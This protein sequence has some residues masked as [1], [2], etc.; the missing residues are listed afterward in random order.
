VFGDHLKKRRQQLGLTQQE[1][2]DKLFVSRQTISNWE[3]GKNYPDIPT[4]ISVSDHLSLSLD[5][6][7]KEDKEYIEKVG[8][9][10]QLINKE[11][12]LSQ[13]LIYLT[14]LFFFLILLSIL[15]LTIN[16]HFEPYLSIILLSLCIPFVIL[17]YFVLREFYPKK[18]TNNSPLFIP[19]I[20]GFGL[21][22]NP[23]HPLGKFIWGFVL[24]T[25]IFALFQTIF[26]LK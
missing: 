7:L 21:T 18:T 1:L 13:L 16:K 17:S 10:Y 2:A 25:I 5:S 4:L 24:L 26:S 3:N 23:H 14:L 22:V 11:K 12:K 9:D 19:K 20:Y 15:V 6:L 8:S